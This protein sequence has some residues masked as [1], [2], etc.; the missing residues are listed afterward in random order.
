M[1]EKE[2]GKEGCLTVLYCLVGQPSLDHLAMCDQ[3]KGPGSYQNLDLF[4]KV[5]WVL[6]PNLTDDEVRPRE[7]MKRRFWKRPGLGSCLYRAVL[8]FLSLTARNKDMDHALVS[9]FLSLHCFSFFWPA[10]IN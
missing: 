3:E 9:P 8:I 1:T 2:R 5:L 4:I 10:V 6:C 7:R